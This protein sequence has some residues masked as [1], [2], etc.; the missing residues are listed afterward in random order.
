MITSN[1]VDLLN[2]LQTNTQTAQMT[3][4]IY[5]AMQRKADGQV[6]G[7][8]GTLQG[9]IAQLNTPELMY[10]FSG[11]DFSLNANDPQNP[12]VLTVGSFPTLAQTFAPLCSLVI[13]VASKLMNQPAKAPSFV[14]LDEAPTVF[15][16]NL[17]VLPNTG[18]SNKVATVLMCQDLA[19]LTDGYGKEKS[20]VLF[21]SCNTH[22]YGRVA[23]SITADI[24]SK[25]FGKTDKVYTTN[26][27]GGSGLQGFIRPYKTESETIQ[28]RDVMKSAAFLQMGV[29]EF[30]GIAVESNVTQF[31]R[32]FLQAD[33]PARQPLSTPPASRF[34]SLSD[35]YQT[36]RNDIDQLLR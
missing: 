33:R 36:V 28:E 5:N 30:A 7:V 11:D 18:R 17:E 32:K 19:Q 6:S 21:A 1:D 12:I 3:M 14:M 16:P 8:I 29:G 26:S 13:T 10:I 15:V 27:E 2:L 34:V 25:Q 20:D 35:Y 31:R 4:S 9:A 23:S 24:L 22:F